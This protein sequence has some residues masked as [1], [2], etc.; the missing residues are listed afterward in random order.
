MIERLG[1]KDELRAAMTFALA[2]APGESDAVLHRFRDI[3]PED[4]FLQNVYLPA[5]RAATLVARGS[6]DAAIDTL[7]HS[8]AYEGGTVAGLA[9]T[10]IR[11]LAHWNRGAVG[12]AARGFRTVLDHR[13][14]DPFSALV[15][16]SQ[17]GLARALASMGAY[18]E[19][20]K[21]YEELLR[22]SRAEDAAFLVIV[23]LASTMF[24]TGTA[25]AQQQPTGLHPQSHSQGQGQPRPRRLQQFDR[26]AGENSGPRIPTWAQRSLASRP[27]SW[28]RR[29][30]V[31][32]V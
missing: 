10:Y 13:G 1:S 2:G 12:D 19:S 29:N 26:R 21:A 9:P 3:R 25:A 23:A 27:S 17:L 4:T 7:R 32:C 6:F 11:A 22:I 15:P 24:L 16:L 18:N 30:G 14:A 20:R 31:P 8:A 5:A 28:A